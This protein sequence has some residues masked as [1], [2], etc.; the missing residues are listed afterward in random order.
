MIRAKRF[1]MIM[2]QIIISRIIFSCSIQGN[3]HPKLNFNTAFH[4]TRGYG[5]YEQYKENHRF[6]NYGLENLELD[7]VLSQEVIL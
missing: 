7:Q 3:C 4:Y 6:S 5:Y 2:K 1:I